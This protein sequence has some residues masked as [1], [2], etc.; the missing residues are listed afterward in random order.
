VLSSTLCQPQLDLV[1]VLE[2][3]VRDHG[4]T[5][6]GLA[7]FQDGPECFHERVYA[8]ADFEVWLL[9]WL[10]G[11]VTPIHDHGGAVTATTVLSGS[12]IEERFVRTFGLNVRP[13]WTMP[14][15]A[16][17]A[18]RI[19][20]SAIHRVRPIGNVV[21]LHLYVPAST[22]GQIYQAVA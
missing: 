1:N 15:V 10:P 22:E 12:L 8:T 19:E 20:A 14:R 7:R 21:T 3:L 6:R 2:G 9:S 17:D 16:G 4:K 13:V 11:Q 5:F 18:D